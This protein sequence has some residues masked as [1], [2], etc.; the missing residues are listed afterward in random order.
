ML[1]LKMRDRLVA[2]IEKRIR[3]FPASAAFLRRV[4]ERFDARIAARFR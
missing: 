2:R 4:L 1:L 3:E